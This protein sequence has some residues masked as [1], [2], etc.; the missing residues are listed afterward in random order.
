MMRANLG[1]FGGVR[2]GSLAPVESPGD[3]SSAMPRGVGSNGDFCAITYTLPIKAGES[4]RGPH[5]ATQSR[6]LAR[7]SCRSG[8]RSQ[9]EVY[10]FGGRT[11]D[12][13]GTRTTLSPDQPVQVGLAP[14]S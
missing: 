9:D 4:C 6:F 1:R 5:R 3:G 10:G 7:C 14:L 11:I 13:E 8:C 12:A 2:S